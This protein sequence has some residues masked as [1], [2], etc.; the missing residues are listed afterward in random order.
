MWPAGEGARLRVPRWRPAPRSPSTWPLS[1]PSP[2]NAHVRPGSGSPRRPRGTRP[3]PC[4]SIYPGHQ[5]ALLPRHV[6]NKG[7]PRR[8][9]GS[10]PSTRVSANETDPV[11]HL[12][13]LIG[14]ALEAELE[15]PLWLAQF[16]PTRVANVWLNK[17]LT[18]SQ[19]SPLFDPFDAAPNTL[20]PAQFPPPPPPP[21]SRRSRSRLSPT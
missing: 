1:A 4:S 16:A 9:I 2:L 11:R 17:R 15:L 10:K 5:P 13:R 7:S 21:A 20:D 8:P 18:T 14:L 6:A 3:A 12:G 19:R